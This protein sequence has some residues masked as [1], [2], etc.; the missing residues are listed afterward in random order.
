MPVKRQAAGVATTQAGKAKK[1]LSP[2]QIAGLEKGRRNRAANIKGRNAARARQTASGQVAGLADLARNPADVIAERPALAEADP[3]TTS[4]ASS[5]GSSEPVRRLSPEEQDE[6]IFSFDMDE[7]EGGDGGQNGPAGSPEG[8]QA[9]QGRA[10]GAGKGSGFKDRLTGFLSR[11]PPASGSNG[12]QS[13][14]EADAQQAAEQWQGLAAVVVVF[15]GARMFGSDLRPSS[16]MANAMAAPLCRIMMRHVGPLRTASADTYDVVAFLTACLV[17]YQTIEPALAARRQESRVQS[18]ATS[19]T[20]SPARFAGAQRA[21]DSEQYSGQP[22]SGANNVVVLPA[23]DTVGRRRYPEESPEDSS[24]SAR[25]GQ[26]QSA[27]GYAGADI[28]Q[29]AVGLQI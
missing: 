24:E 1:P 22:P 18:V 10:G 20:A 7:G 9:T 14:Q 15:I 2:A 13:Q 27:N 21:P 5:L 26:G 17:Y 3:S 29:E 8:Q 6:L 12:T 4:S 16:K 19:Q 25:R 11:T 23:Q 28:I